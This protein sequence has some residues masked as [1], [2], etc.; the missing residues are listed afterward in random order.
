MS[1]LFSASGGGIRDVGGELHTAA[2]VTVLTTVAAAVLGALAARNESRL[3][4]L[5][6]D[7]PRGNRAVARGLI[8]LA[9]VALI[10]F[11]VATGN[12]FSWIGD[13]V[14]EFR[15]AGTPNLS[16]SGS[17]YG[18]NVGSNRYDAWRVALSDAGDDPIF[19]DGGGGYRYSYLVKRQAATQDI[20][21]AHSV[22]LE[23]LSELG[24]VGLILLIA[25]VGGA[26]VGAYRARPLGPTARIVSAAA[27]A[28]GTYWIV[29]TSVDW[30]WPYPAITA[31]VL[32]LLGSAAAPAARVVGQ[33]LDPG[34][35]LVGDRRPGGA[36]AEHGRPLS[37]GPLHESRK[38][39][40]PNGSP[41][42][43]HE[44]SAAPTT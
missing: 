23:V 43:D 36:R 27:L 42:G 22:E 25:A 32:A 4:G 35:A 1:A 28:S 18:F 31:P 20:H 9:A 33:A 44:T 10:G 13:R 7:T 40:R 3:R 41:A 17:R 16:A 39:G 38:R 8:A 24:V 30:F 14:D 34:V 29:H 2:L 26:F 12:P 6:N 21:D 19:G 37:G 11:V 15:N 5:G